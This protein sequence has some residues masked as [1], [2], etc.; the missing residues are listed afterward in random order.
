MRP[1]KTEANAPS[2]VLNPMWAYSIIWVSRNAVP[3]RIVSTRPAWSPRRLFRLID[4]SAQC[5]VKLEV[6]RI[7]VLIAG[8]ELRELEAVGGGQAAARAASRVDDADE[9]V[10]GEER[11]E[12]HRLGADEQEHPEDRRLD[13]RALVRDRRPVMVVPVAAARRASRSAPRRGRSCRRLLRGRRRRGSRG[14]RRARRT[15]TGPPTTCGISSKL[16]IG[17]G[18]ETCHSSVIARHGFD[19]AIGPRAQLTITL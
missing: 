19:S 16:K 5:I 15:R 4:C 3:I 8:D 17:G 14:A 11:A 6:T 12:Q 13:P 10:R 2:P 18:D 7:A 1:K 9:E